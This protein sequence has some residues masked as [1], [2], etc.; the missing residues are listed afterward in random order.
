MDILD[1]SWWLFTGFLPT[2]FV[3]GQGLSPLVRVSTRSSIRNRTPGLL[4]RLLPEHPRIGVYLIG[5]V[6]QK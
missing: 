3:K 2:W 4:T 5:A 1:L 6:N